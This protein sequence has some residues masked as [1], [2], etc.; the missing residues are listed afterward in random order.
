MH[1]RLLKQDCVYIKWPRETLV[2]LL[3]D[4]PNIKS[5]L[6]AVLG[7]QTAKLWLRSVELKQFTRDVSAHCIFVLVTSER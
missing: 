4:Q 7:I 5:A 6:R 2:N 1:M 3:N